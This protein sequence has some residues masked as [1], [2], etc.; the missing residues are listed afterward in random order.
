MDN[1]NNILIFSNILHIIVWIQPSNSRLMAAA[2]VCAPS[3]SS[4]LT[5]LLYLM[6]FL[7]TEAKNDGVRYN[8]TQYIYQKQQKEFLPTKILKTQLKK[9]NQCLPQKLLRQISPL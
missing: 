7:F 3:H 5:F 4:I 8:M 6:I 1:I 9:I 2:C